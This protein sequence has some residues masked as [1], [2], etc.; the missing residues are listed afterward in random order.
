VADSARYSKREGAEPVRRTVNVEF[1]AKELGISRPV[2]YRSIEDGTF[3]LPVIK[4][5]RRIVI[6]KA[7]LDALLGDVEAA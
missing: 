6:P 2:A 7:A 1:A 3:P 5:G 4:I